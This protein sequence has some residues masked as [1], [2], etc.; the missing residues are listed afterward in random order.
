METALLLWKTPNIDPHMH[1]PFENERNA[2]I[3]LYHG[4]ENE[5][6]REHGYCLSKT[7]SSRPASFSS[8]KR[9]SFWIII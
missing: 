3:E 6:A 5:E 2:S 9:H 7:E 4:L 1:E 8:G